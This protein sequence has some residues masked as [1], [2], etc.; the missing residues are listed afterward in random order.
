MSDYFSQHTEYQR[1]FKIKNKLYDDFYLQY[2]KD[3]EKYLS[4]FSNANI[5]E[6][7]CGMGKFTYFCDKIWVRD[8][9]GIDIDDYFFE[10]NK[11]DFPDYNFVKIWFQEYLNKH[12]DEFDI[13][14][15]SHVFEHLDEKERVE[16]IESIYGWLKK[17][18]IWINY[19]PNADT[20]LR[21][22]M[23]RYGDLTHKFIYTN[24][25]FDQVVKSTGLLFEIENHNIYIWV[26][27]K[28][29][30][31]IHLIFRF[32]TK[33]YFLGMGE[34]FPEFYTWEFIN[35]LTKKWK[36]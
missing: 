7:W 1:L 10:Y 16:M 34:W 17:W 11:K 19:M 36:I 22:G 35:V 4:K 30:R 15:V 9:T 24:I 20:F 32:F 31:A 33:I 28:F 25:S 5:L 27:N 21:L 18:W 29:R 14:F 8:Y 26:K 23:C 3:L 12:K 2:K 13:I 6:I